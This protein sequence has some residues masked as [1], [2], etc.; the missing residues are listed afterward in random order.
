MS[1][2]SGRPVKIISFSA[3]PDNPQA[4]FKSIVMFGQGQIDREPCGTCTCA[5]MASL[6]KKGRL[7]IGDPFLQESIIGT[8]ARA[9]I[10]GTTEIEGQTAVVP[11]IT[12]TV[13]VTG[14][15]QFLIDESDTLKEGY[16]LSA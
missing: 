3:A 10:V 11:E 13:Y 15:H 16:L 14:I 7:G 5:K 8:Y 9:T 4:D 12:Y 2:T 6:F 1:L